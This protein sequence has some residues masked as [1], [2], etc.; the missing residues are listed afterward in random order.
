MLLHAAWPLR[1][2]EKHLLV[3]KPFSHHNLDNLTLL[4]FRLTL[5]ILEQVEGNNKDGD[6]LAMRTLPCPE[7]MP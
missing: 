3:M 7:K 6:I 4:H 2:D 1:M 5:K